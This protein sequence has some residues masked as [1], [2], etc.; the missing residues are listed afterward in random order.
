MSGVVAVPL[1]VRCFEDGSLLDMLSIKDGFYGLSGVGGFEV[2][3]S[4][5]D[6]VD[7]EVV[8]GEVDMGEPGYV[9][10]AIVDVGSG[11]MVR[12]ES[13]EELERYNVSGLLY[14]M[15]YCDVGD[16]VLPDLGWKQDGV[17]SGLLDMGVV[18]DCL[19]EYIARRLDRDILVDN[20]LSVGEGFSIGFRGGMLDGGWVSFWPSFEDKKRICGSICH[21]CGL[22]IDGGKDYV[23]LDGNEYGI[24][25][26]SFLGGDESVDEERYLV[27]SL[28]GNLFDEAIDGDVYRFR[29]EEGVN[30]GD[31]ECEG[32]DEI[33]AGVL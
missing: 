10:R 11:E 30:P 5:F 20:M 31:V 14:T 26:D 1:V 25:F 16:L 18:E 23:D 17:V 22:T 3:F 6:C 12:F 28:S 21:E 2:S 29:F 32:I 19:K 24:D 27:S 33:V 7:I 4:K 15:S 8:E 9:G 13:K